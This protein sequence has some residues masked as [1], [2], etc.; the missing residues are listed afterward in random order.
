M[1][2]RPAE[3]GAKSFHMKALGKLLQLAG[4]VLLPISMIGQLGNAFDLRQMLMA[5]MFGLALFYCGR[6]VEGFAK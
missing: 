6:I 3:T 5:M 2:I 4:L 1:D